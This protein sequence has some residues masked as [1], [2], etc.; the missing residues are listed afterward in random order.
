M[1]ASEASRFNRRVAL[2][3]G[4]ARTS[5]WVPMGATRPSPDSSAAA[6]YLGYDAPRAAYWAYW[7]RP[8]TWDSHELANLY[9]GDDAYVVFPTD[10]DL[11]LVASAPPVERA[12]RWRTDHTAAYLASVRSCESIGPHIGSERPVSEVRGVLKTRYFFRVS[13]GPGWALIGDAGHHKDFFAGL[14]ISD[15]LRDA[16]E[17]SLAILETDGAHLDCWWRRRDVQRI[18]MFYWAAD[19]GRPEP[20][21]ALRRMTAARLATAPELRARF[22]DIWGG[23]LSPYEL[24]PASRAARW[25]A[26]SVLHGDPRPFIPLVGA[27]RRR[28]RAARE[29]RRRMK[30]LR[31][32]EHRPAHGL[33]ART[34]SNRIGNR[35]GQAKPNE[36]PG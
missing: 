5:S 13:A 25:V 19:L 15:A 32:A 34:S 8:A 18:E 17:L 36:L 22:G 11:L 30:A 20:V 28:A 16:H 3:N 35:S 27:A 9:F 33:A 1:G 6:E 12:R 10:G 4:C 7:R 21:D 14:G 26:S 29:L 24:V 2:A 31:R 23:R